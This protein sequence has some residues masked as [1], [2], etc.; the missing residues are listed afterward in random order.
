LEEGA[1]KPGIELKTDR[2][3]PDEISDVLRKRYDRFVKSF[4]QFN[5]EDVFQ[6]LY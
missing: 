6:N 3:K 5:S 4:G 2:K 1:E